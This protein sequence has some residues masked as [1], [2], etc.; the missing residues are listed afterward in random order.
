MFSLVQWKFFYKSKNFQINDEKS[1]EMDYI[2]R[3]PLI[4]QFL[5]PLTTFAEQNYKLLASIDHDKL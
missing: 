1:S 3:N 4:L 2:L 5:K